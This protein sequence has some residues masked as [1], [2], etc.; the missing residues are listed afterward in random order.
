[1]VKIQ[2]F[3]YAYVPLVDDN[4][5]FPNFYDLQGKIVIGPYNGHKFLFNGILSRDAVNVVSGENR[6]TP[7]SVGVFNI[8]NNDLV[9]AAWHFAP[10]QKILNKVILSLYRNNGT[11]DFNSQILDPSL[12]RN[13]FENTI[14]V[15]MTVIINQVYDFLKF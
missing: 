13:A 11:T 6:E 5:T 1:M 2:N 15:Q 3:N 7:D 10:N 4:T 8:T 14:G 9:S 12:N